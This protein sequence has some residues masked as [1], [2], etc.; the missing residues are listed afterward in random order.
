MSSQ[1]FLKDPETLFALE[2]MRERYWYNMA[3]RI[4]NA[5]RISQSFQHTVRSLSVP[6]WPR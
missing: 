3:A 1:V 5:Y 6:C 2:D 4:T